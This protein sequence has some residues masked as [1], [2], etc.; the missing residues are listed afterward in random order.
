MERVWFSTA[1]LTS[2][3]QLVDSTSRGTTF[4]DSTIGPYMLV[5]EEVPVEMLADEGQGERVII[6]L[7][8]EYNPIAFDLLL[9]A[10][11]LFE[12]LPGNV[13]GLKR[14]DLRALEDA[15]VPYD[16]VELSAPV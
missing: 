13:Y 12:C 7:S 15:C 3:R 14:Q 4:V 5:H 16:L 8:D 1:G 6:R 2:A 11:V 9:R 10:G